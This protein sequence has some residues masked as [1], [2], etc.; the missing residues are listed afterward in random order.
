MCYRSV[1]GVYDDEQPESR[2]EAEEAARAQENPLDFAFTGF[3]QLLE[4]AVR[5]RVL[6]AYDRPFQVR[7][8]SNSNAAKVNEFYIAH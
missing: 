2:A 8:P 1:A 4:T 5:E 3:V 6:A 7:W